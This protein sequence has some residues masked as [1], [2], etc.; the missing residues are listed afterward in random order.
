VL[1]ASA[2]FAQNWQPAVT[3]ARFENRAYSGDLASQLHAKSATWFGYAVKSTRRSSDQNCCARC[4]LERSWTENSD[5]VT[6]TPVALEGTDMIAVLFRVENDAIEKIH[7][8]SMSC[9]LDAGGLP[10]LWIT[11][12]PA[13]A[14]LS[15]LEQLTKS[16]TSES[17]RDSA[18][19]AISQHDGAAALTLLETL[20]RPPQPAHVRGQAI[21]WLAQRAGERAASFIAGAIENDPDT[22]VKKKAVFA[23]SQ[24][25]RDEGVPRLI[26]VA[27]QNKN[28][29]VKKQ[30]FFWL[31]QSQDPRALAY[32]E[33]VLER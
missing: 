29:E 17:L 10:F 28:R 20:A 25:P 9:P 12:V 24:L 26:E 30:A 27:R 4:R 14:S 7:V 32:I 23:L 31:G 18:V 22:E 15:L 16:S 1:L 19:F 5:C 33:Q 21:F 11:G 2:A 8:D 6:T 3:N 13:A